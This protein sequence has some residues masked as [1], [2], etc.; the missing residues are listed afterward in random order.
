MRILLLNQY[1][2]PDLAASAQIATDLAV[3]LAAAGHEVTAVA[4]RGIYA[5]ENRRRPVRETHDGVEI[6]RLPCTNFGRRRLAG[7]LA[8]YATFFASMFLFAPFARKADVVVVMSTPPLLPLAGM[9]ARLFRKGRLVVW[10]QDVYPEVAIELGALRPGLLARGLAAA[11]RRIL[12]GADRVVAIG[13]V[14][15]ERL[16]AAGAPSARIRVVENWSDGRLVRRIPEGTGGPRGELGLVGK[17]V[18][19]YSGNLGNA[20]DFSGLEAAIESLA[21]T[22]PDIRFVFVGEGA[23]KRRL[24]ERFPPGHPTVRFLPYREKSDLGESLGLGDLHLVTQKAGLEGLVV[25]SKFYGILAAGRPMLFVG[26]AR[27]EVAARV[28]ELGIGSRVD[29]S[30][31]PAIERE[32]LA[33]SRRSAGDR[34][35]IGEQ[36]RRLFDERFDR[37]LRTSEFARVL[38]EIAGPVASGQSGS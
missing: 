3:D 11:S 25:P 24:G 35:A 36:A 32:I 14:M 12:A 23:Q 19:L 38:A 37:R 2:H 5:G 33:W 13:E 21:S 18:V 34:Q 22:H 7:R 15:A 16:V 10:V 29:P 30:D 27:S 26:P 1:F 8:D 31:G 6:V 17:F 9:V 20:H 28:S 4:G